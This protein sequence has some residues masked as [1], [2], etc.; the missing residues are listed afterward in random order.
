[1]LNQTCKPAQLK[2]FEETYMSRILQKEENY[3]YDLPPSLTHDSS[4]YIIRFEI[5]NRKKHDKQSETCDKLRNHCR[6][7]SFFLKKN[8]NKNVWN[9]FQNKNSKKKLE[10]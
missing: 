3:K 7:I 1:M 2:T 10:I 5:Q 9:I 6:R 4:H 8:K